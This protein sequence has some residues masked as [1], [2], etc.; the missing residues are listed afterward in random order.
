MVFQ[1]TIK[2]EVE[3]KGVGLHSGKPVSLKF[4]PSLSNSGINFVRTD[5]SEKPVIKADIS[6]LLEQEQSFRRTS[7]AISYLSS[8]GQKFAEV[9][10]IEHLMAALFGL[11]IDNL[12]IEIDGPEVPGADGSALAFFELLEKAGSIKQETKHKPF[13]IR[14][15]LFIHSHTDIALVILPDADFKVSYTLDYPSSFSS[16]HLIIKFSSVAEENKMIFKKELAAARTF[17]LKSEIEK[18]QKDGLGKGA[19]YKNTLIIDGDKVI[20]NTLRFDDEFARHKILDLLGDFY[21]LGLPLKGYAIGVKSGHG[22]NTRLLKKVR[23]QEEKIRSGGIP[24]PLSTYSFKTV[25]DARDIQDILPH[26]YP[27]LLVDKILELEEDKRI[28]GV[29]NVSIS[30]YF[31]QGHFPGHPVMPGV[32]IVEALA[33]TAGILLLSK[34]EN[35]GK[36]AYFMG[37]DKARFRQ[38]VAPGDQLKLEVEV[39]RLRKNSGQ[40]CAKALVEDKVVAEA[41][42]MFVLGGR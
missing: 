23:K 6:N 26:R 40:V 31:F 34:E 14:E 16:Q 37:I 15:P 2:K 7:I 5:L 19:N 30:E 39:I 10:T 18:L 17:C 27:F 38:K 36:I 25:L 35:R 28:T 32:L 8:E 3:L 12:L 24:F 42:L 9:Q 41:N 4:K 13:Q 33:Q 20:D 1:Q 22:A 29:K 21:L 11:G